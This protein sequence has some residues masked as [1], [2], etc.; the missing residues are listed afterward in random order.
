MLIMAESGF[1]HYILADSFD[2]AR[3]AFRV[4][5][6]IV[7]FNGF[8]T[9]EELMRASAEP[10]EEEIIFLRASAGSRREGVRVS[11]QA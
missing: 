1:D 3:N 2:E 11:R 5:D 10:E 4:F 6:P 8:L 7:G 9:G